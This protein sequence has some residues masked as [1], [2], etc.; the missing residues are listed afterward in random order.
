M[1]KNKTCSEKQRTAQR[2]SLLGKLAL[3]ELEAFA[4]SHF[5]PTAHQTSARWGPRIE[6]QRCSSQSRLS[7][8]E[9]EAF[10][11]SLL[12]ILFA[13]FAASIAGKEA[14]G[15]QLLAQFNVELK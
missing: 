4:G 9:L 14:F 7:L 13:L 2:P 8:A 5:H 3:G 12:S 1:S 11:G 10:A 6:K 15:F